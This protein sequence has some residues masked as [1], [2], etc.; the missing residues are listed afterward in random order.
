MSSG[1]VG[2][3][4]FNKLNYDSQAD[5]VCGIKKQL[6]E[7]KGFID[8][9]LSEISKIPAQRMQTTKGAAKLLMRIPKT[10]NPPAPPPPPASQ[11]QV[12][13]VLRTI[14]S[15]LERISVD[16]RAIVRDEN[17]KKLITEVGS[18]LSIITL[19]CSPQDTIGISTLHLLA[20][21]FPGNFLKD[22][23]NLCKQ[24]DHI[25]LGT[26]NDLRSRNE[27]QGVSFVAWTTDSSGNKWDEIFPQ[28][29]QYVVDN[30]GIIEFFATEKSFGLDEDEVEVEKQT[31]NYYS[32]DRLIEAYEAYDREEKF[33]EHGMTLYE[34]VHLLKREPPAKFTMFISDEVNASILDLRSARPPGPEIFQRLHY[35]DRVTLQVLT[36]PTEA[37][38]IDPSSLV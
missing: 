10:K 33:I 26:T 20:S 16:S 4:A 24:Q 36:N 37:G 3:V 27:L 14:S 12:V 18:L 28:R 17:L 8:N 2:D 38:P 30:G 25:V 22:F 15:C 7:L 31:I 21:N 32:A 35:P 9:K 5:V 34:L 23:Y 13:N 19:R 6:F 29:V 11:S 1:G